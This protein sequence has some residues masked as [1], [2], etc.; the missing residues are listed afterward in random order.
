LKK[1][2]HNKYTTIGRAFL[3]TKVAV[4]CNMRYNYLS[5]PGSKRRELLDMIGGFVIYDY[6]MERKVNPFCT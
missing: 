2:L 6:S 4:L 1:Y 5:R 3:V